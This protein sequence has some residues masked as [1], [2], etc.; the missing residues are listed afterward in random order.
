M[1]YILMETKLKSF[2][3]LN[4]NQKIRRMKFTLAHELC[5]HIKDYRD[6]NHFTFKRR[7]LIG[8]HLI[9]DLKVLRID[10]PPKF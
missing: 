2:I 10:L 4:S 8:V 6:E 9:M 7:K 5:H 1:D 3:G